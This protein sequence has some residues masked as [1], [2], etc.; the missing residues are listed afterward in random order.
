MYID[1]QIQGHF[2]SSRIGS[3]QK[4]LVPRM[5]RQGYTRF[6]VAIKLMKFSHWQTRRTL[7]SVGLKAFYGTCNLRTT[8][9]RK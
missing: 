8:A 5:C 4:H 2:I 6:L 7:S 9:V 3:L 1:N